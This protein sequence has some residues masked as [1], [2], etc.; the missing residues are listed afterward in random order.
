MAAGRDDLEVRFD[1]CDVDGRDRWLDDGRAVDADEPEHGHGAVDD[2][3]ADVAVRRDEERLEELEDP[4]GEQHARRVLEDDRAEPEDEDR[5]GK[6][7]EVSKRL[8][9]E[10]RDFVRQLDRDVA[11][12]EELVDVRDE[13]RDDERGEQAFRA[14]EVCRPAAFDRLD[15]QQEQA[16][17]RDDHDGRVIDL[18]EL[19]QLVVDAARQALRDGRDHEERED[20]HGAV[21]GEPEDATDIIRPFVAEDLRHAGDEDEE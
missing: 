11:A 1:V 2:G 4:S 14:H 19:R 10:V 21:V 12:D 17:D 7:D 18:A 3:D 15:G 16:D 5:S 20:A 13:E 6:R 9:D 8:R